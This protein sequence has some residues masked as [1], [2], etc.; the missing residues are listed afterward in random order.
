MERLGVSYVQIPTPNWEMKR[1]PLL[2]RNDTFI[3]GPISF[4]LLFTVCLIV[5]YVM[6]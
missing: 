4:F 5:A 3:E 6:C 2:A 1:I